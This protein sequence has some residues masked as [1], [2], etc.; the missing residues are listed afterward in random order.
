M[1]R[2]KRLYLFIKIIK[3]STNRAIYV[4]SEDGNLYCLDANTGALKWKYATNGPIQSSPTV[5]NSIV[6]FGSNDNYLYAVDATTGILKWQYYMYPAAYYN[7]PIFSNGYIFISSTGGIGELFSINATTG[8]LRW[9]H[10]NLFYPQSPTIANGKIFLGTAGNGFYAFDEITGNIIW[11]DNGN[12][13]ISHLNPAVLNN[14]VYLSGE[15]YFYC[16]DQNNGNIIWSSPCYANMSSPTIDNNITYFGTVDYQN[17]YHL[18]ACNLSTGAIIFEYPPVIDVYFKRFSSPVVENDKVYANNVNG[19]LYALN[20]TN[21]NVVWQFTELGYPLQNDNNIP[22][23]TVA[24]GAIYT[25]TFNNKVYSLNASDGSVL[26]NF[27]ANDPIYSG[28]CVVDTLG[29][30]FHA[31]TSGSKN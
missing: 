19:N 13:G 6:Y 17:K 11:D 22:S 4:G 25:G 14:R 21:G 15:Y 27:T 12:I 28:P 20:K 16:M 23:P 1:L 31:G 8:I 26:W 7:S 24:N 18:R 10:S 30:V 3:K 2:L 9:K 5:V 29:N